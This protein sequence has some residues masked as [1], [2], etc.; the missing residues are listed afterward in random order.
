[1]E[2]VMKKEAVA[3]AYVSAKEQYAEYGVDVDAAMKRLASIPISMHCWQGDDVGGF[4]TFGA[5][6]SGGGI[7]ATGNYPGKART[8]DELRSNIEKALS[9]IPGR[10]RLNLHAC[11][12]DNGGNYIDRNQIEPKHF[13]SWIDWAKQHKLGM[14]FNP[15]YFSH[16]NAADGFT[17]SHTDQGIRDFW[18][19]HGIACR[20]IGAEMGRQLG[21]STVTNF[22]IPDGYKDIPV[23]RTGPRMRLKES[24]DSIFAEKIDPAIHL[25]AVESKLF[26]LGAESYTVGSHEFYMGYAVSRQKLLCL[27]SG[28]FHPTEMISEKISSVLMFC[29]QLLL[30]V[31]RPVRWDSDHVVVLDDELQAIAKELIRSGKIDQIHIGLD[32]FDASINRVAA[33]VIGMRN[34][35][36][37]LLIALLEP[38]SQLQKLELAKD[39]TQRLALMEEM[40]T[41]PWAAV[42]DYYCTV[43][44]V[45]AGM[46]WM[47]EI[48]G[49]TT[50]IY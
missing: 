19:E 42:W 13:Q 36:K 15:T 14:D 33:W 30:H 2:Q 29:P 7:Q 18:V 10:H 45:P 41:L 8:I 38:F 24:L 43:K 23:D 27:D 17:L 21:T 4:E 49:R 1:M 3:Q 32:Y 34:M 28:H 40:K 9:V 20:R 26:G 22:W 39:Y 25:D 6:L 11:Y 50:P 16:K 46:S 31:S 5:E 48:Q 44:E 47:N 37:A 12:L 35:L